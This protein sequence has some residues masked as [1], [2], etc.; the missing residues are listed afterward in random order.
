MIKLLGVYLFVF[1]LWNTLSEGI[2][3]D[4]KSTTHTNHIICEVF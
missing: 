1:V 3:V 2:G 4:I